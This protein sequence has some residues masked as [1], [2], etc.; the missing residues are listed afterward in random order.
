MTAD[1]MFENAGWKKSTEWKADYAYAK[2]YTFSSGDVIEEYY[3]ILFKDGKVVVGIADE[4]YTE[5]T[6]LDVDF[7]TMLAIAKKIEEIK[8]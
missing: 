1:K 4:V 6:E 7:D 5:F 2:D 8:A 3:Y